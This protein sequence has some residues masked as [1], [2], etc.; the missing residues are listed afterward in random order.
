[1]VELLA[2]GHSWSGGGGPITLTPLV[3]LFLTV[4]LAKSVFQLRLTLAVLGIAVFLGTMFA[5]GAE[6]WGLTTTASIWIVAALIVAG[7]VRNVRGSFEGN[8]SD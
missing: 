6:T 5:M 7:R 1:M 8:L 2:T 4:L 3:G